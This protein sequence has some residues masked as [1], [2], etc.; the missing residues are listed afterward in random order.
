ML[1]DAGMAYHQIALQKNDSTYYG[2]AAAAYRDFIGA[3]PR[4]KRANECH[5]NYAE[6]LFSVGDYHQAAQEYMAVSKRYPDSK[7]RETAAW[8]A[9]V[10]SQNLL[11]QEEIRRQ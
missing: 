1:Y 7:Y 5:Y 8:N 10:A 11:K 3:Y 4:S 6:I 2:R 9:I